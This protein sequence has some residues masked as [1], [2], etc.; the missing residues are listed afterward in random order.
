MFSGIRNSWA[1][2]K[3]S[4]GVLRADKELLVFPILSG[5]VGLVVLV[6]FL[7]PSLLSGVFDSLLGGAAQGIGLAVGLAFYA[8]ESFVVL[9]ANSALIGAAMIRLRGGNPTIGDG[10]RIASKHVGAIFV[11]SFFSGTVGM[12]LRI[13]ARGGKGLGRLG[14]AIGGLAWNLVTYLVL[15]VLV[16]EEINPVEAIIRSATLLKKTWGEQIVGNL[17]TDAVFGL[18][19]LVVIGLIILVVSLGIPSG[20][21]VA[22]ALVIALLVVILL[23]LG[24]IESTLRGIYVAAVYRY[25]AQGEAG[26]FF[27]EEV[28]KGAFRPK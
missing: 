27:S 2:I 24:L 25:A 18:P 20:S 23:L 16:V 26:G 15:P 1:L 7:L 8:V 19:K 22:L 12:I 5:L 14:A 6:G 10:F 11:F 4:A 28:V 13:L 21:P 17:S 3:A 9:F